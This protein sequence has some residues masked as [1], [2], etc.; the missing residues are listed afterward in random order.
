MYVRIQ[1]VRQDILNETSEDIVVSWNQ[2]VK[3]RTLFVVVAATTNELF[4]EK[5]H[6][7]FMGV[8]RNSVIY[9]QRF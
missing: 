5:S 4:P 2:Y 6:F 3:N 1:Y 7:N 9:D 8:A